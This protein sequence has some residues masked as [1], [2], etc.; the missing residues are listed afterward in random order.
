MEQVR[1]E[2]S[3]E[4]DRDQREALEH[5]QMELRQARAALARVGGGVA[6]AEAELQEAID[7]AKQRRNEA[8]ARLTSLEAEEKRLRAEAHELDRRV[9]AKK[10]EDSLLARGAQLRDKYV[11]W[12]PD[13]R[14]PLPPWVEKV[15]FGGV[16]LLLVVELLLWLSGRL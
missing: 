3:G 4:N 16:G 15:I 2:A 10:E 9:Q 14:K 13:N 1:T 5:L 6:I 11:D 8:Q 12:N 7:A